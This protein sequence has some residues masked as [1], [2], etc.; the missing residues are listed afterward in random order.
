MKNITLYIIILIGVL[1]LY[2]GT[3]YFGLQLRKKE[4][5][6]SNLKSAILISQIAN[7]P[8]SVCSNVYWTDTISLTENVQITDDSPKEAKIYIDGKQQ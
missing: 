7:K 3:I 5:Q 2:I 6:L 8:H 1:I 4:E